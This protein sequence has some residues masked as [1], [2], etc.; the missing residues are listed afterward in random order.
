MPTTIHWHG[1][2]VPFEM[3]G[4]A[5]MGS[6]IRVGDSFRY[7]FVVNQEAGTYWY[8]PHFDTRRQVDLG[9][10]GAF[11]LEEPAE[12]R[13]DQE[14]IVFFDSWGEDPGS[15][16]HTGHRDGTRLTW[17]ANGQ[18]DPERVTTSGETLRL[19]LVN[20]S[21]A[22]YVQLD[23]AG[24]RQIAAGQGLLAA[25]RFN[26]TNLLAPGDRRDF[27]IRIGEDTVDLRRLPYSIHG[28]QVRG[29]PHRLFSIQPDTPRASPPPLAW[30]FSRRA[31]SSDPGY[32]DILY[33]FQG[34]TDLERWFINGE[35]F[36][37]ITIEEVPHDSRQIIE[38]RNASPTEHPFHLH[39]HGFEV[40]SVNGEP[41]SEYTF[42]DTYNI[43][44]RARVRL[45]LHANN[46]GDWM[47][48]CHIL[49]HADEGMMTVL[50]VL[51]PVIRD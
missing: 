50:R 20:A 34:D 12:P 45:L 42:E 26:D 38:I 25:E 24:L 41:V 37:D 44:I 19:R 15:T 47:T 14:L 1:L 3:D 35:R 2:H 6:P 29:T 21:N 10:Y 46:P 8:H 48:H 30:P 40:L 5:W 4:V 51:D 9:L 43:P 17:T 7:E 13:P 23:S 32:T 36:P 11:V 31:P 28:G 18:L 16:G 27:E 49:P 33:V 39:G 22:G